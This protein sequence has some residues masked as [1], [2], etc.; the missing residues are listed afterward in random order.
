MMISSIITSGQNP[1][2]NSVINLSI[3]AGNKNSM[4]KENYVVGSPYKNENFFN[5]CN[6]FE[7]FPQ[8]L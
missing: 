2:L 3:E 5:I 1:T 7:F 6:P 8:Q 4:N